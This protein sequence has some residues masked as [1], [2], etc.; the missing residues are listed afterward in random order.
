MGSIQGLGEYA[1]GGF[2]R[3]TTPPQNPKGFAAKRPPCALAQGGQR[4]RSRRQIAPPL[5]RRRSLREALV[6]WG[7]K[8]LR[9]K[10]AGGAL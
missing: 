10:L 6:R 7:K 1:C 5:K 4:R 9:E 8:D 2:S 3:R